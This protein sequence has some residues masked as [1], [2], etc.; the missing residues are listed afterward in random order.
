[1][2]VSTTEDIL[3]HLSVNASTT[4]ESLESYL[5]RAEKGFLKKV[6]GPEQV[7]VFSSATTDPDVLEAIE[8][9]K[10][11]VC[12][13]AYYLYL[14]IGAVQVTDAGIFVASSQDAQ[15]I[16]DKQFKELQRS[17]LKAS[18]ELLDDLLEVMEE[19]PDKFTEFFNSKQY[20]SIISSLLVNKTS[21][22]N[23]YYYIFNS[24]QTF[25][26][27]RPTIE[28]VED[29]FITPTIGDLTLDSLKSDVTGSEQKMVKELL[30]KAIVAF[31]IMKVVNNG[32][33][34]LDAQGIH[35]K[36]DVLPY[37]KNVTNVNLK[38]NDFLIH[39]QNSKQ[40]EGEEYLKKALKVIQDNPTVFTDYVAPVKT[41][42][43]LIYSTKS[44]IGI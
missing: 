19:S 42:L 13:H 27:I 38:V 2:I 9:A 4:F 25:L 26:A 3:Q 15:P 41:K 30:Q 18:H 5:K 44:T 20:T 24:R 37:E 23:K 35:M 1:M 14:P 33:F 10:G 16:S 28:T 17:F 43:D 22:F 29:Q 21:V 6:I 11:V 8:L 7:A 34:V 12:N 31:A 32:M 39:T 36:F 40:N